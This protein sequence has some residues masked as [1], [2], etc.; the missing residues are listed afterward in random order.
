MGDT[1]WVGEGSQA[2]DED[3]L[4]EL[5]RADIGHPPATAVDRAVAAV[6][7]RL[8]ESGEQCAELLE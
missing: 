3:A 2:S 8:R 7:Q 5:L 4:L 6:Q 1:S